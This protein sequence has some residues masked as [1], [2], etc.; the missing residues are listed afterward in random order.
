MKLRVGLVSAAHV[1]TPSYA[2]QFAVHPRSEIAGVWDDNAARGEQFATERGLRFFPHLD[3]LLSACDAVAISSENTKHLAQIEACASSGRHILCEKPIVVRREDFQPLR[4][5]VRNSGV[6]FMTAFPCRFS[7]GW[8]VIK[9]KIRNGDLG[10]LVSINAT[11]RGQCPQSW[12]VQPD[13]SGGGAMIDHVVHVGDLL[14]EL[15]GVSP[16]NVYAQ[17][18]SNTY[19]GKD[20]DDT[21][22]L[23]L[24]YESG[25]FVT[26][27]SS[28]SRPGSFKTWGDVTLKI[29]GTKG[30]LHVDLFGQGLD[31]FS[32][33]AG[34]HQVIGYA[35]DLD[36]AMVDAF[37]RVCLDD[38]EVPVTLEDGLAAVEIAIRGYESVKSKIPVGV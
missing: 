14:N 30:V 1:H 37:I 34:N 33:A 11:N 17:V 23:T 20:W 5:S 9:E 27:D 25:V 6:K 28:W 19:G 18:G 7:P 32:N 26:L 10:D 36:A 2:H 13:L 16:K 35:S 29:V 38:A 31:W 3:D 12:F 22:M 8:Q 15:F 21:A 4:A 24:D